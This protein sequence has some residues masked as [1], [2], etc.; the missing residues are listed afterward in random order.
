MIGTMFATWVALL[1][2]NGQTAIVR[3]NGGNGYVELA[4]QGIA[5]VL[6]SGAFSDC[7]HALTNWVF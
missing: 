1:L 4:Q 5:Q 2:E 6:A 3:M 7:L